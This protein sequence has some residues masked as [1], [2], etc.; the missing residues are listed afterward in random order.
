MNCLLVN[1]STYGARSLA[2]C[3]YYVKILLSDS[4]SSHKGATARS[5]RHSRLIG[6]SIL[7]ITRFT[8]VLSEFLCFI[9]VGRTYTKIFYEYAEI[10]WKIFV[11]DHHSVNFF[12][13]VLAQ[14]WVIAKALIRLV[15]I[16][17]HINIGAVFILKRLLYC[18]A[19][20]V[21]KQVLYGHIC[22]ARHVIHLTER[23]L[24]VVEN[25]ASQF[26][27]FIW[28]LQN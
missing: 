13:G 18:F 27:N 14:S 3:G 15:L 12:H 25:A 21:L 6:L 1:F 19:H 2:C 7:L 8:H 26:Y 28:S 24:R 5:K 16:I 22:A 20:T 4:K 17:S 10:N 11:F 9:Y 23:V